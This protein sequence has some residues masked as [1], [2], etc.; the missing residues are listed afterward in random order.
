MVQVSLV[1]YISKQLETGRNLEDVKSYL[2]QQGY[3]ERE[4]DS[5]AQYAHNL[6]FN[7]QHAQNQR[8]E[9]LAVYVEQQMKAGYQVPQIKQYLISSGYP[10]YEIDSA[11]NLIQKPKKAEHHVLIAAIVIVVLMGGAILAITAMNLHL[12]ASQEIPGAGELLDVKAKKLTTAPIA[13]ESLDFQ[14]DVFNLGAAK[15]YDV[16]VDYKIVD[17][18][19]GEAISGQ[20]ETFALE[21]STSKVLAIDIPRNAAAGKYLLEVDASYE[22]QTA[23]AGFIFDV[24]PTEQVEEIT[25]DIPIQ[26]KSIP[27]LPEDFLERIE[28]A[29][30]GEI[31]LPDIPGIALPPTTEPAEEEPDVIP[32]EP[33]PEL[34]DVSSSGM[35]GMLKQEKL[36]LIKRTSLI[37]PIKAVSQCKT[38]TY[39]SQ[40]RDC[41]RDV[42]KFKKDASLCAYVDSAIDK[43]SCYMEMFIEFPEQT[44]CTKVQNENLVRSCNMMQQANQMRERFNMPLPTIS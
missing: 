3:D 23:K 36:E 39:E 21:T 40:Q 29:T 34:P 30:G 32:E 10:Y 19:T 11:I 6:K 1:E 27:G 28:E 41:I 43:E 42:A 37:D 12:F 33:L 4:V 15:R 14:L 8:V 26:N 44:D 38:F 5:S 13:G 20:K 25:P 16:I 18:E 22:D 24:Y 9:Q 35:E 17:R 2:K 7:P 31:E